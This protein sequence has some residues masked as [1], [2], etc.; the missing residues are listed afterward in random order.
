MKGSAK[1]STIVP[2]KPLHVHTVHQKQVRHV[3]PDIPK[4]P[5][6]NY[7]MKVRIQQ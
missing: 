5:E 6:K 7:S 3:C 1:C 2:D 4:R